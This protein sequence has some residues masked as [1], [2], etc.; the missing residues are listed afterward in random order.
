MSS[1]KGSFI[2]LPKGLSYSFCKGRLRAADLH[3]V[4]GLGV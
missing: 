4:P 2:G 3:R 1:G